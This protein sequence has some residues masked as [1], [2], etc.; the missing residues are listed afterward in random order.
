VKDKARGIQNSFHKYCKKI[1]TKIKIKAKLRMALE[2]NYINKKMFLRRIVL[3]KICPISVKCG[4]K[5]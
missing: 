5:S 4:E 1:K 3:L 2:A